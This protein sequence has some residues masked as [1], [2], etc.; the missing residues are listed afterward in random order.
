MSSPEVPGEVAGEAH[1]S[2]RPG[3]NRG[4]GPRSREYPCPPLPLSHYAHKFHE[5]CDALGWNAF[6]TPQA[7]LSR[8]HNGRPPTVLPRSDAANDVSRP[9]PTCS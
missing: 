7:A 5:G 1:S 6:P 3:A 2:E 8:P 4:E 9:V